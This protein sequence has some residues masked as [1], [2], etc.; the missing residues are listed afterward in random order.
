MA[1][2]QYNTRRVLFRILAFLYFMI[3]SRVTQFFCRIFLVA[4]DF[5]GRVYY[6]AVLTLPMILA[7]NLLNGRTRSVVLYTSEIWK[8]FA[9]C[10][11]F[12]CTSELLFSRGMTRWISVPPIFWNFIYLRFPGEMIIKTK[13][14][15][16]TYDYLNIFHMFLYK[17]QCGH[18]RFL[19][20]KFLQL[21]EPIGKYYMFPKL[22]SFGLN[23]YLF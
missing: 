6:T 3:L 19:G 20:N 9:E 22:A 1:L 17:W 21:H 5:A 8:C 4:H 15:E 18:Y 16:I 23:T 7:L 12:V 10:V 14:D 2:W 11:F 13:V